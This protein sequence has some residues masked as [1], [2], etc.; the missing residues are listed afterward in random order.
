MS[1]DSILLDKETLDILS[2]N[3]RITILKSLKSRRKTNSE[4]ADE[5]SLTPSTI[6]FHLEKLEENRLIKSVKTDRK[7]VYYE[8]TSRG[9]ALLNPNA[10]IQLHIIIS[11]ILVFSTSLSIIYV[12]YT[13]PRLAA[14]PFFPSTFSDPLLLPMIIGFA[15]I[16]IQAIFVIL[17]LKHIK[18][19]DKNR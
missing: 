13:M 19:F 15:S 9:F 16:I 12:Y 17:Y 14:A 7:W 18:M 2:S 8:I 6:H 11:T 5:L 4:L 3:T 10:N 1:N